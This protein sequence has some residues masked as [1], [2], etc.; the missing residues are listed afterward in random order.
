MASRSITDWLLKG[1]EMRVPCDAYCM[2]WVGADGSVKLC[3]VTFL[4]GSLHATAFMS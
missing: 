4:L 2:V 3:C 1:P